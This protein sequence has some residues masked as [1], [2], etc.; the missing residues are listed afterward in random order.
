MASGKNTIGGAVLG[1]LAEKQREKSIPNIPE[2]DKI[3]LNVGGVQHV[4]TFTT[5]LKKPDTRLYNVAV[6]AK[7]K[8]LK[9]VYFDRHPAVFAHILNFYRTDSLHVPTDLCGPMIKDELKY[10]Q[11]DENQ[12][13]Q[14]C[15]VN[16]CHYEDTLEMLRKFEADHSL[17]FRGNYRGDE[18][19]LWSRSRPKIWNW[20]QDPYSSKGALAYAILSLCI[21][22]CSITV[23]ILETL[24]Y[25]GSVTI[26]AKR[27]NITITSM[28]LRNDLDIFNDV[29]PNDLL[30]I[31]DNTCNIFF[32]VEFVIK[33]LTAPSKLRFLRQPLTIVELLCLIPYYIAITLIFTHSDPVRI[34]EFIRILLAS[35]VL[36]IF[37]IFV[38]M[39]HFLA[40]K[41]LVY[42]MRASAKEL[43]LLVFIVIIGIII[44]A[45]LEYYMEMFTDIESD[46]EHIPLAFWW[47]LITMTTVGYGDIY[48]KS[49]LGYIVGGLCA[50]SGVLVIALSVPVI[51][52]NFT[53]YYTHAQ[54]R[55]KLKERR[56]RQN[57]ANHW[58]KGMTMV[59]RN[60]IQQR[61]LVNGKGPRVGV[62]LDL[63]DSVNGQLPRSAT[64]T[65]IPNP[66]PK[67]NNTD[68]SEDKP[69]T[70]TSRTLSNIPLIDT[71][72]GTANSEIP[73]PGAVETT[74]SKLKRLFVSQ[75]APQNAN[76]DAVTN[77]SDKK[78]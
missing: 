24:P 12:I 37:R 76:G 64:N 23:F 63:E 42:T 22:T 55:A 28:D 13:E 26:H 32:F 31:I 61:I 75:T 74:E 16:Y 6:V 9:E 25:F 60:T 58:R 1:L 54:S 45:C 8:G 11:L 71:S 10:W 40:L 21:V 20:L 46:F 69:G 70:V 27:R 43:L 4:T 30:I 66:T 56:R 65:P 15:W 52:N 67:S 36:R 3:I 29:S 72:D 78:S 35:R 62:V 34:F 5:L 57:V 49:G 14:C 38:L 17:K 7:K 19:S 59:R 68:D 41:I 44:F 47:A 2:S 39:K 33:F 77:L 18:S 51:V 53:V 50:I 48:P 73:L